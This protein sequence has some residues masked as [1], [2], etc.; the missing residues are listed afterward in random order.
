LRKVYDVA[1]GSCAVRVIAEW[2]DALRSTPRD[3]Q[4]GGDDGVVKGNDEV[5]IEV[6]LR[7]VMMLGC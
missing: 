7:P 3:V 1:L 6:Y 5:E 2:G 4:R